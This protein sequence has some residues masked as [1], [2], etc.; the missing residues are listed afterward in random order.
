MVRHIVAILSIALAASSA[1]AGEKAA[2]GSLAW[3]TGAWSTS[4]SE[5][6]IE[7]MWTA[8]AGGTMIGAGRTVSGGTT[9]FFEFL[10]IE[11]RDGTLVYI[12]SP[13]GGASTEFAMS[14]SGATS[15]TFANPK[16]D[17]PQKISY[18][19]EGAKL[20]ARVEGE[21]APSEEW[22]HSPVVRRGDPL[23]AR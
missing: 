13:R 1:L 10:R 12:A 16:H 18:W 7:E 19:R 14:A 6:V 23:K 21:G 20:C 4:T 3:M 15:V 2:I 17:F 11:E 22:C 9:T 5:S 8:P